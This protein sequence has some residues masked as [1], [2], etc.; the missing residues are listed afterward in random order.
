MKGITMATNLVTPAPAPAVPETLFQ[1]ILR[2]IFE[3]GI[4]AAAIFVKNPA[5]QQ[6]A[7]NIITI[8]QTIFPHL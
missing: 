4:G 5:S 8:L 1:T 6:R 7:A 3:L 2:D